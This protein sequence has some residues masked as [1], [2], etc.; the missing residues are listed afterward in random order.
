MKVGTWT[1]GS[2]GHPFLPTP[3]PSLFR[4]M[5]FLYVF[6]AFRNNSW[7]FSSAYKSPRRACLNA[8]GV[9][10]LRGLIP[11][12]SKSA[13]LPYP[14]RLLTG[15]LFQDPWIQKLANSLPPFWPELSISFFFPPWFL[16]FL[17]GCLL[18]ALV[19][20]DWCSPSPFHSLWLVWVCI[21]GEGVTCACARLRL[22]DF[23]QRLLAG[24]SVS[25]SHREEGSFLPKG[26][27]CSDIA[28]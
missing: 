10:F 24:V 20:R 9:L 23:L 1:H 19:L 21:G 6:L 14:K 13:L 28:A 8:C 18:A 27:S 22:S 17:E 11:F 16:S 26:Q 7:P 12:P 2:Q 5:Y 4:S 25:S 15:S 3:Q